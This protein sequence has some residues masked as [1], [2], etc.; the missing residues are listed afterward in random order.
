MNASFII[1]ALALAAFAIVDASG[2]PYV[3]RSHPRLLVTAE[4]V[5]G[6]RSI[7]SVRRDIRNGRSAELWRELLTKVEREMREPL[8]VAGTKRNRS[9]P[10]VATT[11]NRIADAALVALVTNERLYAE[12]ALAQIEVLFDKEKWPEWAD[13]AHLDA[14]LNSDLR[15]GQFARAIGFA[16]DWMHGLLTPEERARIVTGLD[17]CAIKPFKASVAANEKWV[18]RQS[19]WKTSVVGGFAILGMA[20]GDDHPEAAWLVE[21]ADPLMESYMEIFGPDGEFNENPGYASSVRFV[22]DHYLAKYYASGGRQKPA[23]LEL[24]RAFSRWILYCI[25]PPK[26]MI[27]FGDAHTA[28]SPNIA[29]FGALASV[30][31]DPVIQWT[32]LEYVDYSRTD[33]RPRAQELLGFDPTVEARPPSGRLPLARN[34]PAQ[35]GIIASRSSWDPNVPVSAVWAKARTEDVHRHADWGQVLID[36]FGERLIVDPGSPPVY[37]KT[38]KRHYYNYQQCGHNVLAFGNDEYD[39][40]WRVRRQGRTTRTSFDDTIGAVWSFD[41]SEV[42]AKE[43][44]VRRHVVHLLP[45][46]VVVL[47]EAE[48]PQ[49][50]RVRLRW[51]T[52]QPAKPDARGRFATGQRGANLAACVVSLSGEVSISNGRHKYLP[53]YDKGRLGNPYPQRHEPF[54]QLQTESDRLQWLSLF[55]VTGPEEKNAAWERNATGWSIKTPEGTVAVEVLKTELLVRRLDNNVEL[56]TPIR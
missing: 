12:A 16:Y 55:C 40:D 10:F 33:S 42:Y 5:P 6:L 52:S 48:L 27:A 14:G 32:Y 37:P 19:N 51:H 24:L 36:G 20:L 38:G 35:S 49:S 44:S 50:E 54:I 45:R 47:D 28:G 18:R 4:S 7:D 53:P 1:A 34:F 11:C 9:Y 26:R 43:R 21:F 13:Q 41:L 39:V 17:R 25:S 2:A 23:Q 22:V 8:I 46:I 31:R 29:Y 3:E 15:H 56:R 30:L